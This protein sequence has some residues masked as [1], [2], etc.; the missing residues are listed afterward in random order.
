MIPAMFNG[1]PLNGVAVSDDGKVYI[2]G[3]LITNKPDMHN[4]YVY[5]RHAN[6]RYYVHR[7]IASTFG[8]YEPGLV[9]DHINRKRSDNR[10]CN[11]RFVTTAQN[12]LNADFHPRKW[13]TCDM[14]GIFHIKVN[15]EKYHAYDTAETW[16]EALRIRALMVDDYCDYEGLGFYVY[17]S[18]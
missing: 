5:F 8:K 15:I 4:G 14:E 10:A 1:K 18:C 13:I 16:D 12:L 9:V 17:H 7:V 3:R 6:K 2:K 11:L